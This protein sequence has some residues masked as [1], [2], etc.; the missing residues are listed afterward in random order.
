ML[1]ANELL[2]E[3]ALDLL[4]SAMY[5]DEF[6][7]EMDAYYQAINIRDAAPLREHIECPE[8]GQYL[9]EDFENGEIDHLDGEV[10]T[11]DT[12]VAYGVN[13]KGEGI[14]AGLATINYLKSIG[15]R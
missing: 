7:E 13:Y 15:G 10:I 1:S 6:M 2:N 14:T 9:K 5:D 8:C 12:V 3:S 4:S 11:L